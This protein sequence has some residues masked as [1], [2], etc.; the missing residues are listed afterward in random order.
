MD[1]LQQE[2][3]PVRVCWSAGA[4]L[5]C[6]LTAT[7]GHHLNSQVQILNQ[8]KQDLERRLKLAQQDK[9]NL[10]HLLEESSDKLMLMES[11]LNEKDLKLGELVVEA[12]EL[13]DSSSWLSAKLE[14]MVSLNERL[15]ARAP[16]EPTADALGQLSERER[17]HLVEQLKELRLKCRTRVKTNQE[18]L[19]LE[20]AQHRRQLR[21]A[22]GK[23]MSWS[24]WR[25][26]RRSSSGAGRQ[27][28]NL[29]EELRNTTNSSGSSLGDELDDEADLSGH[30][31]LSGARRRRR[32]KTPDHLLAEISSLLRKFH[33]NLLHRK[34]SIQLAG[35]S[36]AFQ[37]DNQTSSGQQV[38]AADSGISTDEGACLGASSRLVPRSLAIE[39]S[40]Q[41]IPSVGR[42]LC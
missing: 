19:L 15:A 9:S 31:H 5:S 1:A 20:T 36:N 23:R 14:T 12:N 18:L 39:R 28:A 32:E 40:I 27:E 41:A 13:R 10:S 25:R 17:S 7:S 2:V 22:E 11:V 24:Q 3:S 33:S 6:L 21:G 8:R 38:A 37:S 30:Q 16:G 42:A 35:H 34:E 29:S 4:F 26:L